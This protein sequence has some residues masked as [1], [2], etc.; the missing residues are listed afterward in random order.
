MTWA[1]CA[2]GPI[3]ATWLVCQGATLALVPAI[4]ADR[5]GACVCAHGADATC[6]MHHKP[7]PGVRVCVMQ[8]AEGN[9]PGTLTSLF[10]IAG[11]LPDPTQTTV[12][13]SM[14]GPVAVELSPAIDRSSPP[15][16]P[17]PRA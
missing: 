16:P 17:P 4:L 10:S 12:A 2:L 15:D 7:T 6:P 5:V 13:A 3:A 1:R 11:V 14:T 9:V 8:G